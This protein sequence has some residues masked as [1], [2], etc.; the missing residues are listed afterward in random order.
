MPPFCIAAY[1]LQRCA[2]CKTLS[3][4]LYI[5]SAF[6]L[7]GY[8]L[9][10]NPT[11]KGSRPNCKQPLA[12]TAQPLVVVLFVGFHAFAQAFEVAFV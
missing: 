8:A 9:R 10:T 1:H 4:S 12:L 7:L 11:Y 2:L 5:G 3:V 6:G